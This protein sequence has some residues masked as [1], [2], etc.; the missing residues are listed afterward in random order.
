MISFY[1]SEFS[2]LL[3]FSM[4]KFFTESHHRDFLDVKHMFCMQK[5][6]N[7][8]NDNSNAKPMLV[9]KFKTF[10]YAM[11]WPTLMNVKRAYNTNIDMLRFIGSQLNAIT[12]ECAFEINPAS[13]RTFK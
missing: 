1:S 12:S 13:I 5:N 8:K 11:S 2:S 6:V 4:I 3:Y 7:S 10:F 9:L